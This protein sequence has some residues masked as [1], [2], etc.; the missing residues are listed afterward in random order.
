[1][2]DMK[3][4]LD[5]HT[6]KTYRKMLGEDREAFIDGF[7]E[8][9]SN[10]QYQILRI[11]D[12]KELEAVFAVISPETFA[13]IFKWFSRKRQ[14][15]LYGIMTQD[16]RMRM[17]ERLSTDDTRR[18]IE[19]MEEADQQEILSR[20]SPTKRRHME[21]LLQY[22]RHSAGSIMRK[23][24]V[25]GAP[26][27]DVNMMVEKLKEDTTTYEAVHF[28]YVVDDDQ[29]LVGLVALRDLLIADDSRKL[30]EICDTSVHTVTVD[31]DQE[32][33]AHIMQDYDIIAVPVVG[34][35]NELLGIITVDD[36]IDIMEFEATEDVGELTASRG[37]TDMN[38][39][40]FRAARKRA[41][42]IMLLMG[43][44]LIT[45]NVIGAFEETLESVVLLS[46]FIPLVM[47]AA[48]NTGT[49]SL[50]VMVRTISTGE[51][52]KHGLW[53]TLG[54]ELGAGVMVGT[55]SGITIIILILVF[56]Q[57]LRLAFIVG[58]SLLLTLSVATVIGTIMPII[59]SKLNIDPAVASGPFITTLNDI[60]GLFIYF[61]IATTL[62]QI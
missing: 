31:M 27:D 24:F 8:L 2:R 43:L 21:E 12:G 60:I 48:G 40:P 9:H 47:D 3:Q 50:A 6:I 39:S 58:I 44:G 49:Q 29:Q 55:A 13:P 59:I 17:L 54:R 32:Q 16:Y 42:W 46:F 14:M 30:K 18:F 34:A 19:P 28:I 22:A 56:Y 36:I 10:E 53:R 7:L 11:L 20:L 1:M 61:S 45:A 41:P 52:Q 35:D 37:T 4:R 15:K 23:E 62:L 51:Y 38:V 26:E 5:P 25:R 33:V 57:E